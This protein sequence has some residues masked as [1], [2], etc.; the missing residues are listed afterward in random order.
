VKGG[1][2]GPLDGKGKG[3]DVGDQ[4]RQRL[5]ETQIAEVT[6]GGLLPWGNKSKGNGWALHEGNLQKRK[7]GVRLE[8]AHLVHLEPGQDFGSRVVDRRNKSK[9][10]MVRGHLIP[11][12]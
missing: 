1:G 10:D 12:F 6:G 9:M 11:R 3:Q 7:G 5:G 2:A 4:P 8:L